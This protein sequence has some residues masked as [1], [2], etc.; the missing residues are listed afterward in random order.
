[1]TFRR[2]LSVLV[3]VGAAVVIGLLAYGLRIRSSATDL[4]DSARRVRS[5]ADAKREIAV[6]QSRTGRD[7]SER[8]VTGGDHEYDIDVDN[9]LLGKL[10][11]TPP[12]MLGVTIAL[13]NGDLRFVEAAMF[14]GKGAGSTAGVLIREWFAAGASNGFRLGRKDEPLNAVVEFSS[15]MRE[16]KR[17][18]IFRLNTKCLVRFGGCKSAED[19]LPGVWQLRTENGQA[20]DYDQ[21]ELHLRSGGQ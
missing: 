8:E 19:I 9:G 18:K 7:F 14:A 13:R 6:W 16:S 1:M 4:L 3:V 2:L 10:G 5:T 15:A 11:V 12:A 17:E 20:G 21:R